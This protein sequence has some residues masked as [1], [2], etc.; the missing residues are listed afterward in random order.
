MSD[1]PLSGWKTAYIGVGSNIGDKLKN[2]LQAIDRMAYIDG[3]RVV[4]RSP[5]Y[6]TEPIGVDAQDWYVNG[7]VRIGTTLGP[8]DLLTALLSIESAMGRVRRRKWESRIIDL[9]ILLYENEVIQE[10]SLVV[11]HPLMHTR[12]FVLEPMA[13]LAPGLI[14]PVLGRS[15]P[16]LMAVIGSEA[17]PAI[18]MGET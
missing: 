14:H 11:P 16:D 7:V 1:V 4:G 5:F 13:Q 18:R 3:C 12:R 15:L 17:Q 8:R 9:D 2:C 10:L 6:Q